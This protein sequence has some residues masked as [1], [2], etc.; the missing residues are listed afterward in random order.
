MRITKSI[1]TDAAKAMTSEKQKQIT[2]LLQKATEILAKW[3]KSTVPHELIQ[4]LS[5]QNRKYIRCSSGIYLVGNG[6]NH[7]WVNLG[8]AL[9]VDDSQRVEPDAKI[10]KQLVDLYDKADAVKRERDLLIKDIEIALFRL[11]T[12][13][14]VTESFPE[15]LPYIPKTAN[16]AVAV[17]LT[18]L[19]NRLK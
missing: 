1:A 13:A 3:Y 19:R 16:A 4:A 15:A 18:N 2:G 14:R 5:T 12:L 8:E 6:F 17:D 10:A 9:P 7:K 11:G